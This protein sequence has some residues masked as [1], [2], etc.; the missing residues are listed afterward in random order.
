MPT[1]SP[2]RLAARTTD[3]A[4]RR[5]AYS[6][7]DRRRQLAGIER[8]LIAGVSVSR[9]EHAMRE[10]FGMTPSATKRAIDAVRRRWTEEERENRAH[11]KAM[12][13]RR[14]YGHIAEARKAANFASVAQLER[15]LAEIQ[16]TREPEALQISVD[17][18]VSEAA[19]SVISG[20][21]RE[22]I[23]ALVAE[24][25]RLRQLAP[26]PPVASMPVVETSGVER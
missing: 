4:N 15:L 22:R 18:T 6:V 3:P 10:E 16:G 12:A 14:I 19:L 2:N 8:L 13:Q 20:L 11:Y 24:Q 25:R 9:V 17:A 26:A 23:E 7:D 5:A 21:T 1:A